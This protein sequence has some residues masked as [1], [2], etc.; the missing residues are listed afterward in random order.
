MGVYHEDIIFVET[1]EDIKLYDRQNPLSPISPGAITIDT[2]EPILDEIDGIFYR[3]V[4]DRLYNI[5]S[6]DVIIDAGARIGTF[7]VKASQIVGDQGLV[8]AIEPEP[9]NYSLLIQNI[10]HNN[11]KNVVPIQKMVW[12]ERKYVTLNLS[13]FSASHSAYSDDYYNNNGRSIDVSADTL[14]NILF[15]IG[16]DKVSFI[17]MDIEGAEIEALKG[18]EEIMQ[19]GTTLAIA[20]YHPVNGLLSKDIIIPEIK[21][22]QYMVSSNEDIVFAYK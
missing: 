3:C 7:S 8:V 18:M 9:Y 5:G 15:D 14:D 12:S 22:V 21:K 2:F 17:K 11:I 19:R 16:I 1:N 4:Y 10:T 13:I 20:A 6:G